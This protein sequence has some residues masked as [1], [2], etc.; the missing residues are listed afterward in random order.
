MEAGIHTIGEA[1]WQ[2][3]LRLQVVVQLPSTVVCLQ[4]GVFRRSYVLRT[5]RA[6]GC[7]QFGRSV[8]EERCSLSQVGAT[9]DATNQPAPQA[10][11]RPRA[12]EKCS[13][14]RQ[15]SFETTEYNPANLTRCLPEGCFL[16]AGIVSLDLPDLPPDFTWIGPAGCENCKRLQP[17]DLSR[18][19][20]SEIL[21]STFANCSQLEQLSPAKKLRRI[22]REAFLKCTSLR[23]V[24][25]PPALLQIAQRA[26]AGCTQLTNFTKQKPERHGEDHMLSIAPL[27]NAISSMHQS[28]FIFSRRIKAVVFCTGR[29]AMCAE[30]AQVTLG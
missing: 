6:P 26:F 17:V 14:L 10:Q 5:V 11:V 1:A 7:K 9:E 21:G 28:G 19:D 23:E 12:F 22:G 8:F 3:C 24:H 2:S 30:D 13:A 4:D 16:E 27:T 20:L 15:V 25:T 29:G 18:A